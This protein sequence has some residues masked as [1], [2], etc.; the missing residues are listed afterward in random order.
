MNV[1]SAWIVIIVIIVMKVEIVLFVWSVMNVWS[2]WIV[3][4]VSMKYVSLSLSEFH[5]INYERLGR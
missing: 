2:A 5:G 1:W 3:I 4:I